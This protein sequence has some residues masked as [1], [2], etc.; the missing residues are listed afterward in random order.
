MLSL[1]NFV[2]L[3]FEQCLSSTV[4]PTCVCQS[5]LEFGDE[6]FDGE[7][8]QVGRGCLGQLLQPHY[9]LCSFGING[10]ESLAQVLRFAM[11]FDDLTQQVEPGGGLVWNCV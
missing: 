3:L 4:L 2:D 9:E 10:R 5:R 11:L 7:A 6:L 8:L 1:Q